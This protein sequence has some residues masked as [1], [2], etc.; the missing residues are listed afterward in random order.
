MHGDLFVLYMQNLDKKSQSR[1]ECSVEFVISTLSIHR[2]T[3]DSVVEYL[4]S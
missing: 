2:E 3:L 4:S 1:G